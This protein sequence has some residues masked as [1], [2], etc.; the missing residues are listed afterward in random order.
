MQHVDAEGGCVLADAVERVQQRAICL[1]DVLDDLVH[2]RTVGLAAVDGAYAQRREIRGALRRS[3]SDHVEARVPS[4]LRSVNA[5]HGT[6]AVDSGE[7]GVSAV[8]R[9]VRRGGGERGGG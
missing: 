8:G 4:E 6:A 3:D 7:I 9:T 1:P 2:D 5:C